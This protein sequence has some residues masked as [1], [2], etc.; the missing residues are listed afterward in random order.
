MGRLI[1]QTSS[2]LR[3]LPKAPVEAYNLSSAP[4]QPFRLAPRARQESNRNLYCYPDP[5]SERQVCFARLSG[6][7][8]DRRYA[9]RALA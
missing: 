7:I 9:G 4:V 2:V 3:Y 1:P 6:G 5:F 8:G